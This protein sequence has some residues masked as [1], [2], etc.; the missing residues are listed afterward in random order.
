MACET[1]VPKSVP[2]SGY[3]Y[4]NRLGRAYLQALEEV[5]GRYGLN[6]LLNLKGLQQYIQELPPN[7]LQRQF[8]FA[9]FSRL[10]QGL[11]EIVGPRGGRGLAPQAG[12][13][14]WLP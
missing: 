10:S 6:A 5:A 8:D 2:R 3:Y 14:H 11:E 9:Y 1:D 7:D 4:P 13:R 12:V